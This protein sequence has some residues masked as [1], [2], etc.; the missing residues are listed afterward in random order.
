MLNVWFVSLDSEP[1]LGTVV[2]LAISQLQHLFL[3]RLY[4][5]SL[6]SLFARLR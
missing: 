1:A 4:I 6:A 2:N 3:Y 5:S